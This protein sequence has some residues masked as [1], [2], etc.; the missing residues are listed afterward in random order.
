MRITSFCS[1]Y[2]ACCFDTPHFGIYWYSHGI[3]PIETNLD[4]AYYIAA[5]IENTY[6]SRE[7]NC[8]KFKRNCYVVLTMPK[9]ADHA[10]LPCG[11]HYASTGRTPFHSMFKLPTTTFSTIHSSTPI[12]ITHTDLN[13]SGNGLMLAKTH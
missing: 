4:T 2:A 12:S 1:D 8:I 7:K 13:T 10:Q 5:A 11:A 3:G 9:L 6:I